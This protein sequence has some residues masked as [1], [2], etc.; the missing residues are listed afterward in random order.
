MEL[1]F[2]L[3]MGLVLR[4]LKPLVMG[5]VLHHL[6]SLVMGI[7]LEMLLGI[8]MIHVHYII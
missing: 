3:V 4:H 7:D 6:K 2:D 5:L 8:G 1:L